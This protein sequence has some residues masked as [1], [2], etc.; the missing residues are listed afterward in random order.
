MSEELSGYSEEE[1]VQ[2]E[3]ETILN[4]PWRSLNSTVL[5]KEL[6]KV[7]VLQWPAYGF[8]P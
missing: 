5:I 3:R 6:I 1:D 2:N 7:N 4:H 8:I